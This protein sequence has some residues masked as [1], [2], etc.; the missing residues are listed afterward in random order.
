ML[1][2]WDAIIVADT[3]TTLKKNITMNCITELSIS[4]SVHCVPI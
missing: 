1:F 3:E 4:Y 2:K